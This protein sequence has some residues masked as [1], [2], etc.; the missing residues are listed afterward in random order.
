M[1]AHAGAE[2]KSRWEKS[3]IVVQSLKSGERR[4]VV[5]AASDGRYVAGGH[6]I[7]ASGGRIMAVP[8]DAKSWE[9]TGEAV[10]LA[11]H[12]QMAWVDGNRAV[13]RVFQWL[14][15][16]GFQASPLRCKSD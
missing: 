16:S 12:V 2:E 6:L 14:H 5:E 10:L 1:V 3:R 13:Q 4:T 9:T 15:G 7:Y 11:D 8:F